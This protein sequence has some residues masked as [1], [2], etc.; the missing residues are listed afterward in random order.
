MDFFVRKFCKWYE[1]IGYDL[2]IGEKE[3]KLSYVTWRI[4]SL[5]ASSSLVTIKI[6][7]NIIQNLPIIIRWFFYLLKIKPLLTSYLDSV[8]NGLNWSMVN[9]K[10]VKKNQFGDHPWFS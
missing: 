9:N 8:L 4:R 1:G 3:G 5:N 6:Y 7:P 10:A 2:K